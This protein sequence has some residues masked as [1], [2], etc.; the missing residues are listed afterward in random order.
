MHKQKM[1][2]III[3]LALALILLAVI[4]AVSAG[5]EDDFV[6]E[7]GILIKYNGTE[8]EVAIPNNVT[9]I[10]RSAFTDCI[11]LE[12]LMIPDSVTSIKNWLF[13]G[14]KNLKEINV[15]ENNHDYSSIDGVLFNK[16]KT[17]LIRYLG[18]KPETSYNI[19]NGVI[20]ITEGAFSF[21]KNLTNVTLPDSLEEIAGFA[22]LDCTSLT[23]III[24]DSVT[25][26]EW[27]AFDDC[28]S[29]TSIVITNSITSIGYAAFSGCENLTIH[30]VSGSYAEE[31]TK[32]NEIKFQEF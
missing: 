8:K 4:P 9:S 26:I 27:K 6:I 32:E 2:K 23:S 18:T 7:N 25:S 30:G 17:K 21:C 1:V 22:F 11:S 10:E 28:A 20:S 14:C 31:Y 29:L 13:N 5:A 15:S 12:S 19:P 16:D 24:P 3:N